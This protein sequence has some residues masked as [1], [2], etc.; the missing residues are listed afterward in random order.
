M[1][2]KTQLIEQLNAFLRGGEAFMSF[3]EAVKDFPVE[4]SNMFPTNVDYTFWHVLEHI[5][6]TQRDIV[7]FIIDPEYKEPHWPDDYWPKKDAKAT[8]K[9]WEKTVGSI[10]KDTQEMIGIVKDEMY[11]LYAKIPK[12]T[13]QTIL[14]EAMLVAN[15]NAYHIGEFAILRQVMGLWK[16]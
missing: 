10:E 1:N 7:D 2:N 3:A 8:K 12:G 4:H 5:R 13:G 11:D 6:L 15:H 16:K 9:D 14:R